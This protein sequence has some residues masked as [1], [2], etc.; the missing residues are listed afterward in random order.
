MTKLR[1][2]YREEIRTLIL[3]C[4]AR[5]FNARQTTEFI[6]KHLKRE[7]S[8]KSLSQSYIERTI[9]ESKDES[10]TWLHMGAYRREKREQS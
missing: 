5:G 3:I 2:V 7:N 8:V 1:E 9:K 6:N 10:N 4:R